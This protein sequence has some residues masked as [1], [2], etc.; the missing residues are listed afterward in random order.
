M[1]ICNKKRNSLE[2]KCIF[3]DWTKKIVLVYSCFLKP[4][5][6]ILVQKEDAFGETK[7]FW[8]VANIGTCVKLNALN[9]IARHILG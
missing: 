3:S 7:Y 5:A 9:S 6:L 2:K 4:K 8:I 1:L